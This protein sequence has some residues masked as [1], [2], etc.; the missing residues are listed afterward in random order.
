MRIS[1]NDIR[2][3]LSVK[4]FLLTLIAYSAVKSIFST[5]YPKKLTLPAA[6]DYLVERH[7]KKGEMLLP[8][9]NR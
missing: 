2:Q 1:K 9:G 7:G 3:L 4:I 6:H 8:S 5:K